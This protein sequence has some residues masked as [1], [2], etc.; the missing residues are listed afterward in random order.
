MVAYFAGATLSGQ[1]QRASGWQQPDHS[2]QRGELPVGYSV[3]RF[4]AT[5]ARSK[6]VVIPRLQTAAADPLSIFLTA[7]YGMHGRFRGRTIYVPNTHHEWPLFGA[8]VHHLSDGLVRAAGISVSG[9]PESV[10]YSP[11][12][13]T[14]FGRPRIL[15]TAG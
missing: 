8:E 10:L 11:G 14:R 5:A 3:H 7:R 9:P 13:R 12:V 1:R 4:G 15:G 6:F 2:R